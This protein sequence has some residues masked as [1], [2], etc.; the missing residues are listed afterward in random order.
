MTELTHGSNVQGIETKAIYRPDTDE[1]E[2]ITPSDT[3][4]KFWIGNSLL[5]A[6]HA[7]VFAQ[8]ICNNQNQG[9]HAFLVPIRNTKDHS[10]LPGIRVLDVGHKVGMNGLDNG[11]IW[12]SNVRIPRTNL[13]NRFGDIDPSS[14]QYISPIKSKGERV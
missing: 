13:L 8:L 1:F 12:F 11:R 14:K 3:A 5:H 10:L 4:Q 6:N 2:I 9:V 7:V